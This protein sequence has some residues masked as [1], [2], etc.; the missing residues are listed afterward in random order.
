MRKYFPK[1]SNS[2]TF[3]ASHPSA[4]SGGI[5]LVVPCRRFLCWGI[6]TSAWICAPRRASH[7]RRDYGGCTNTHG[8]TEGLIRTAQSSRGH[9][10]K[11]RSRHGPVFDDWQIAFA[12]PASAVRAP[13]CY[14][15]ARI[16]AARFS[17]V[18]L[19]SCVRLE[20]RATSFHRPVSLNRKYVIRT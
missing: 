5:G 8:G 7:L 10:G 2:L 9:I 1:R 14:L 4:G 20:T 19:G 15:A 17:R 11:L 3:S 6:F 16:A 12:L 18:C 13:R